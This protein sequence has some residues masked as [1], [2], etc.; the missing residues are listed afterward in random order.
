MDSRPT[1]LTAALEGTSTAV[2]A[3]ARCCAQICLLPLPALPPDPDPSPRRE[4]RLLFLR[5]AAELNPSNL[6]RSPLASAFLQQQLLQQRQL[7]VCP[8]QP[9]AR[10]ATLKDRGLAILPVFAFE[11]VPANFTDLSVRPHYVE[12]AR[13][14]LR[15][16]THGNYRASMKRVRQNQFFHFTHASYERGP[17][18]AQAHLREIDIAV[19]ARSSAVRRTGS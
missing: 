12:P 16:V 13:L 9:K 14:R 18:L 4:S 15:A 8:Q 3:W 2:A 11:V 5:A 19:R 10:G 17:D 1:S 6:A 7:T